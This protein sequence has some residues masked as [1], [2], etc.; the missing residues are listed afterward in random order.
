MSRICFLEESRAAENHG[1]RGCDS[2]HPSPTM[3]RWATTL[4]FVIPTGA[5]SDFLHRG[6]AA[7]N[8][9]D[10]KSG[11]AQGRDLQFHSQ[12]KRMYGG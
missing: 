1:W 6:T 3:P 5:D 7:A 4:K 9:L 12:L 2:V 8:K 11:V 10:R